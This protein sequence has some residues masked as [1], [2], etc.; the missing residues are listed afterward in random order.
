MYAL[1][2]AA[3]GLPAVAPSEA[4]ASQLRINTP[5]AKIIIGLVCLLTLIGATLEIVRAK[6]SFPFTFD[7]QCY[8]KRPVDQ[9]G[10]TSGLLEMPLAPEVKQITINLKPGQPILDHRPLNIDVSVRDSASMLIFSETLLLSA[11][12][13]RSYSVEIPENDQSETKNKIF[14]I[15]LARCFIPRNLGMN[16]D[17]RRLG[18]QLESITTSH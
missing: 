13:P 12:S 3:K 1:A 5:L 18:I 10:W 7:T 8:K 16:E 14:S 4:S 2:L 11:T 6:T 17:G 15:K 9:D